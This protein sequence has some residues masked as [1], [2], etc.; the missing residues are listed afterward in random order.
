MIP[1]CHEVRLLWAILRKAVVQR[2]SVQKVFLKNS[3]NSQENTCVR[4]SFLIKLQI[5]RLVCNFIKNATLAQVTGVFLWIFATFLRTTFLQNTFSG[6]FYF[7]ITSEAVARTCSIKKV[8]LEISQNSQENTCTSFSF[9]IKL[10][11]SGL[12]ILGNMYVVI[13]TIFVL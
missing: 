6:C 5:L 1:V 9:L 2:C 13:V 7:W 3:Q 8:F 11:A 12:W 10:Q 4:V